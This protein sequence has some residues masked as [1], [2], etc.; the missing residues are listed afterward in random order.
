MELVPGTFLSSYGSQNVP[1]VPVVP[2]SWETGQNQTDTKPRHIKEPK[3]KPDEDRQEDKMVVEAWIRGFPG[4]NYD[5][6]LVR[7]M[8]PYE[9]RLRQIIREI[10]EKPTWSLKE[11]IAVGRR[12]D[13]ELARLHDIGELAVD[14]ETVWSLARGLGISYAHIFDPLFM[15][16][17][18]RDNYHSLTQDE[19]DYVEQLQSSDV[20]L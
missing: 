12:A 20:I 19:K 3:D 7:R 5:Y 11:L 1:V 13:H 8:V 15:D 14:R 2:P 16:A 9:M 17:L 18:E 10:Q 4:P 6:K